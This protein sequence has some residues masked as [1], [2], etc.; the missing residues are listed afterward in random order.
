MLLPSAARVTSVKLSLEKSLPK[1]LSRLVEWLFHLRQ[2][3]WWDISMV[4]LKKIIH[5]FFQSNVIRASIMRW[6]KRAFFPSCYFFDVVT[7]LLSF[8][9]YSFLFK[10]KKILCVR[11]FIPLP[12]PAG[13]PPRERKNDAGRLEIDR[14]ETCYFSD[15]TSA[16]MRGKKKKTKHFAND[17][18]NQFRVDERPR[19]KKNGNWREKKNNFLKNFLHKREI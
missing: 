3:W 5:F 15:L 18:K 6:R 10:K 17:S 19:K 1:T 12:P 16:E 9:L 2:N 11:L 14:A 13:V 8:S 4:N 7:L